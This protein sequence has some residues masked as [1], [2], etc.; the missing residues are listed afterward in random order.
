MPA[1]IVTYSAEV[2]SVHS[3]TE[4]WLLQITAPATHNLH[5]KSHFIAVRTVATT[6]YY[7]TF[8]VYRIA[9]AGVGGTTVTGVVRNGLT[10]TAIASTAMKGSFATSNPVAGTGGGVID[11]ID[12]PVGPYGTPY[13]RDPDDIVIEAGKSI[14]YSIER[15]TGSSTPEVAITVVVWEVPK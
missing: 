7:S 13:N 8:R 11:S 10:Q 9:T 1:Q 3:T 6:D 2:A 12:L 15:N 5:I 14:A 4:T